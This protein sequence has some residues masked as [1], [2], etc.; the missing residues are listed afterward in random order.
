MK[1]PLETKAWYLDESLRSRQTIHMTIFKV[2]AYLTLLGIAIFLLIGLFLPARYQVQQ[3]IL[4]FNHTPDEAFAAVENYQMWKEW[5][6]WH[7][8]EGRYEYSGEMSHLG[9]RMDW[10]GP[11]AGK[12]S[13]TM[14]EKVQGE[15]IVSRLDF[16]SPLRGTALNS[17]G[18]RA[19]PEGCEIIWTTEGENSYPVGRYLMMFFRTRL[20]N[21]LKQGLNNLK[22]L[23]E[24]ESKA[25][26]ETGT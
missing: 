1:I 7:D 20:E 12:G 16:V 22:A 24:K 11:N 25:S 4:V 21:E 14:I 8:P 10:D 18:F 19:Y 15:K 17:W 9:A 6:P 26:L 2:T 5:S 13:M 3:S 23:L